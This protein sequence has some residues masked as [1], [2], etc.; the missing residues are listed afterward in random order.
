MRRYR[1]WTSPEFPESE[2]IGA[3]SYGKLGATLP[4]GNEVVLAGKGARFEI[5]DQF[6]IE[7]LLRFHPTICDPAV[8]KSVAGLFVVR[9][10]LEDFSQML[11]ALLFQPAFSALLGHLPVAFD[12]LGRLR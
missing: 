6:A 11:L 10:Q 7:R 9:V 5:P 2:W 3:V 12:R 1:N 8:S 4:W